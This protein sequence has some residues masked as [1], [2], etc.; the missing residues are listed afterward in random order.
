MAKLL[1]LGPNN[2]LEFSGKLG[3]VVGVK[4]KNGTFYVRRNTKKYHDANTPKQQQQRGR[5]RAMSKLISRLNESIIRP[6]WHTYSNKHAGT[7]LFSK[8]NYALIGSDG[9]ISDYSKLQISIGR[10]PLPFNMRA[11]VDEDIEGLIN[12]EWNGM[13][14]RYP[15]YN[16]QLNAFAICGDDMVL[17]DNIEVDEKNH[18]AEFQ[19]PLP[20][21]SSIHLYLFFSAEVGWQKN[22]YS[23]SKYQYIESL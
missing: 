21:G 13:P 2:N 23:Q 12:V 10:M 6:I 5:I 7:T 3:D 18:R 4:M 8:A 19:L 17:V 9:K 14:P 22:E 15:R 16:R 11:S 20:K 1:G